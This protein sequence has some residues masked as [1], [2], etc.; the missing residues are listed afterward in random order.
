MA[1]GQSLYFP[2]PVICYSFPSLRDNTCIGI[3]ASYKSGLCLEVVSEW[4]RSL[5]SE[6]ECMNYGNIILNME[7]IYVCGLEQVRLPNN[8]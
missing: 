6:E 2:I 8:P 7:G 3:K 5:Q 4:Q 1:W